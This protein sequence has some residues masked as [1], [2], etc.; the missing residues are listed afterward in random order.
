MFDP[1]NCAACLPAVHWFAVVEIWST[2]G[3]W[4]SCYAA[5]EPSR[6]QE[7]VDYSGRVCPC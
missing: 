5:G 2:C 7:M 6:G 4:R 1:G 3:C